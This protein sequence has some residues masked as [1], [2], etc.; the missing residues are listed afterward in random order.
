[1]EFYLQTIGRILSV[2][3]GVIKSDR[4]FI[5]AGQ[6]LR[7]ARPRV[8]SSHVTDTCLPRPAVMSLY[9]KA[10]G[11]YPPRI[12]CFVC[13][14]SGPADYPLYS[15]PLTATPATRPV[16]H[17]PFLARLEPPPGSPAPGPDTAVA[18][19]RACYSALMRQVGQHLEI[20]TR[21]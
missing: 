7:Q 10:A 16:P 1:M 3:W 19:C 6:F 11:G 21:F 2:D 5:L 4:V 8:I 14:A 15:A 20:G 9:Y 18:A 17:F 12:L 13:G